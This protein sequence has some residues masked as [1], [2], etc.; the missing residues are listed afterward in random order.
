M[1]LRDSRGWWGPAPAVGLLAV[2]ALGLILYWPSLQFGFF[3]DDPAWFG[4]VA[5]R[6]LLETL[7]PQADFQ[8]YRPAT[9]LVTRLFMRADGTC[10]PAPLHAAQVA[11]HLASTLLAYALCRQLALSCR[12]A[13]AAAAMFAALPFAHQVVTWTQ[14]VGPAWVTACLLAAAN[15]YAVARRARR[16]GAWLLAALALYVVALAF[17]ESAVPYAGVMI[18]LEWALR[19]QRSERGQAGGAGGSQGHGPQAWRPLRPAA[20]GGRPSEQTPPELHGGRWM[21]AA[22]RPPPVA[23]GLGPRGWILAPGA[24]IVAAGLYMIVWFFAPKAEGFLGP[25]F[26]LE[27]AAYLS[28]GIAYPLLGRPGG[29]DPGA[30]PAWAV[31]AIAAGAATWLVCVHARAGRLA[32]AALGLGWC[33]AAL[34]PGWAGLPAVY[35]LLAPRMFYPAAFG[36]VLLWAG[37]IEAGPA[38]GRLRRAWAALVWILL[39]AIIVQSLLLVAGFNALYAAGTRQMAALVDWST[40]APAAGALFV[41][42]PDRYAPA[43]PPYP[44]GYWGLTLAPVVEDLGAYPRLEN[45]TALRTV[46]LS[47]P[48]LDFDER[49]ASPYVFDLRGV[50][51]GPAKLYGAAAE[52]GR[53]LV[54]RYRPDGSMRLLEVGQVVRGTEPAG[55]SL[56]RFGTALALEA[57]T[58]ERGLG[59]WR[60]MLAWRCLAPA[61]PEDTVFVHLGLAGQPPLAQADGDL[62]GG[63]VPA[64]ACQAGDLI[65]DR[66]VLSLP[67]G[68]LPDGVQ[69]RVGAYSRADG[70]RLR[71]TDATGAPLPDEAW[72]VR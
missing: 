27:V 1:R 6:G 50:I 72:V 52:S 3:W 4:R 13:L 64:A 42:Y 32:P 61:Q 38:F 71:A 23:R 41:N 11:L 70:Y 31:A 68:T 2:L 45:G 16:G 55:T 39:A 29:W 63:L 21:A 20:T 36:I 43:R 35:V 12:A 17:Q 14:A 7:V 25:R 66:R 67:A 18:L 24:F 58:V 30:L 34:L 28:Q 15:A 65:V 10:D 33:V 49:A 56:A 40:G 9:M 37:L 47:A 53:I 59:E 26:S 69:V 46:S 22:Q 8:F 44:I 19:S 62:L 48:E 51:A 5:G 60:V 54:T 57:A